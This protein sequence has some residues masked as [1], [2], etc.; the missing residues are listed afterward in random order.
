MVNDHR[1]FLHP[2][3]CIG[4]R[5]ELQVFSYVRATNI[6]DDYSNMNKNYQT[7]LAQ[8]YEMLTSETSLSCTHL[9]KNQVRAN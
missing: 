8:G 4:S 2:R 5:D 6:P 1:K 3:V 7:E 9:A